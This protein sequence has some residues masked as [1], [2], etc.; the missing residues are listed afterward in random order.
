MYKSTKFLA[1]VEWAQIHTMKSWAV[2]PRAWAHWRGKRGK[3]GSGERGLT[4]WARLLTF[5]LNSPGKSY[6]LDRAPAAAAVPPHWW[7]LLSTGPGSRT[8]SPSSPRAAGGLCTPS[9]S[10]VFHP[11]AWRQSTT[12]QTAWEL[13]KP[14][15]GS[16]SQRSSTDTNT[17]HSCASFYTLMTKDLK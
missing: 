3:E 14:L 11:S 16:A 15:K 4:E 9:L 5:S 2:S 17:H 7:W 12:R 10:Q 8:T 6:G 1:G 13:W